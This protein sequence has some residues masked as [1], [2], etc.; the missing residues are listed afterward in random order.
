ME[1]GLRQAARPAQF[2]HHRLEHA[3]GA[4]L[5][6]RAPVEHLAQHAGAAAAPSPEPLA[7]G[8]GA[9][10]GDDLARRQRLE[11]DRHLVGPDDGPPVD[12]HP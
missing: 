8:P 12:E 11:R 5:A 4:P 2:G 10:D 3:V 7:E 9:G 6:E 1:V